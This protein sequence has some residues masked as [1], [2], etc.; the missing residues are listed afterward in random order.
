M[1]IWYHGCFRGIENV[2][3][4]FFGTF[5][6]YFLRR[7]RSVKFLALHPLTLC[8]SKVICNLSYPNLIGKLTLRAYRD[9]TFNHYW[10]IW[11]CLQ[12]SKYVNNNFA[13]VW[14]WIID[15]AK[16]NKSCSTEYTISCAKFG[17]TPLLPIILLFKLIHG[18]Y[19]M[20]FLLTISCAR[21]GC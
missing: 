19:L 14:Y 4:I 8:K 15:Q 5:F 7:P 20:G 12:V 2:L 18:S 13:F 10:S 6:F 16:C 9:I 11:L 3:F 1:Q 17:T 21:M